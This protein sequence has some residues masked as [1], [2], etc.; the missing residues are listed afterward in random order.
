[1]GDLF[2]K[3]YRNSFLR[4]KIFQYLKISNQYYLTYNYYEF[5]LSLIIKTKNEVLLIEKLNYLLE[6]SQKDNY[7]H[8]ININYY[9]LYK[10]F[11]WK[12]LDFQIFYKIYKIFQFEIEQQFKK[13][14]N[15]LDSLLVSIENYETL[16]FIVDIFN[17]TIFDCKNLEKFSFT[18]S[19]ESKKRFKILLDLIIIPQDNNNKLNFEE[20]IFKVLEKIVEKKL[21]KEFGP[22]VLNKIGLFESNASNLTFLEKIIEYSDEFMFK[23]VLEIFKKKL[24]SNMDP[25]DSKIKVYDI[26]VSIKTID[27]FKIKPCSLMKSSMFE[28]LKVMI[29]LPDDFIKKLKNSFVS[30]IIVKDP[31]IAQFVLKT[32]AFDSLINNIKFLPTC[33]NNDLSN[34]IELSKKAPTTIWRGL[35]SSEY[36]TVEKFQFFLK[37]GINLQKIFDSNRTFS[38][39]ND[40]PLVKLYTKYYKPPLTLLI[41]V[42]NE[43]HQ[44]IL[45]YLFE[46]YWFDH[47]KIQLTSIENQSQIIYSGYNYFTLLESSIKYDQQL[48][49]NNLDLN[50]IKSLK[51]QDI[52]ILIENMFERLLQSPPLCRVSRYKFFNKLNSLPYFNDYISRKTFEYKTKTLNHH[53]FESNG[54]SKKKLLPFILKKW[55]TEITNSENQI[56]FEKNEFLNILFLCIN[57]NWVFFIDQYLKKQLVLNKSNSFKKRLLHDLLVSNPRV[58]LYLISIG[59]YCEK[60]IEYIFEIFIQSNNHY[61]TIKLI[62]FILFSKNEF[63]D[64][65][66]R[67]LKSSVKLQN[68]S[69]LEYLLNIKRNKSHQQTIIENQFKLS[70]IQYKFLKNFGVS[71]NGY[72]PLIIDD[73]N[74][75]NLNFSNF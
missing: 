34:A 69:L 11:K 41:S 13:V 56:Q 46:N 48:L 15:S 16:K 38:I 40:L 25:F 72:K 62:D 12:E 68:D 10:I 42:A 7:K 71:F 45:N 17:P 57:N 43:N 1:M 47:F 23:M 51:I 22:M 63:C 28:L 5:P 37:N 61:F 3:V 67:I 52:K 19:C 21:S 65:L 30:S 29:S 20:S 33:L 58:I 64:L 50:L 32:R 39:Q 75:K 8:Y 54:Q 14:S 27:Q 18:S 6:N 26:K 9:C 44:E 2:F 70:D 59:F 73:F 74:N 60:E 36:L 35:S 24:N 49:F 55:S 31:S 66:I 53:L 4:K